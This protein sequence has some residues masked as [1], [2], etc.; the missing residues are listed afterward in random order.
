MSVCVTASDSSRCEVG[1]EVV[2]CE[3]HQH[4]DINVVDELIAVNV[5]QLFNMIFTDS[6]FYAE[7][8]RRRHTA[9]M[10]D[11]LSSVTEL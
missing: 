8:S 10:S 2:Q 1:G 6:P 3:G 4:F 7:F 9:G 11:S 5:D